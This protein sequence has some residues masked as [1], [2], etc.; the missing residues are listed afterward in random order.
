V[1]DT[2]HAEIAKQ[3]DIA[4]EL[5]PRLEER[6][7]A[8]EAARQ[9]P[10]ETVRDYLS[11]GLLRVSQPE[12][13]GGQ[14]LP[15]SAVLEIARE[16]ARGCASAGWCYAIWASHNWFV[17][18]YPKEAQD[19]YWSDSQDTLSAT[20][21]DPSG[22]QAVPAEGGYRLT[23]RWSFL[24]GSDHAT[25]AIVSVF[26]DQGMMSMMVPSSDYTLDD[27]WFVSG[28]RGSGSKDVIVEDVFV[29]AHRV[30]PMATALA[31]QTPGRV[32][33]D[34]PNYRI[35]LMSIFPFTLAA[36]A[37]GAAR[38]AL[39]A[40]ERIAKRRA[41]NPMASPAQVGANAQRLGLA[42]AEVEAAER[43]LRTRVAEILDRA[44]RNEEADPETRWAC[45]RDHALVAKLCRD[46]VN[47][48][49]DAAGGHALYD[50]EPLQ[51]FHRDVH[52]IT[53]HVALAGDG[54]F[55][56]YGRTRIGAAPEGFLF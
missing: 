16:L 33:L 11:S 29:P 42:W 53:H 28:L 15:Y 9:I 34:V 26:G 40:F 3:L 24:S 8:T 20:S 1:Q 5:V 43:T 55:A 18:M 31:G 36:P 46:A 47:R 37:I 10:E 22:G 52:A 14:G 35:P 45:R 39:E 56:D 48:V 13:Y 49:F 4:R 7:A 23:G 51:R 41:E 50:S 19:E 54:L 25:W 38:G 6:S 17:G 32:V 21:F 2:D 27:T 44:E 30:L 12:S